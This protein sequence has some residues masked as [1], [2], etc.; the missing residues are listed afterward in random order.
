MDFLD[1]IEMKRLFL[2]V[3]K[4]LGRKIDILGMD[5]CLIS[6]DDR[7]CPPLLRRNTSPSDRKAHNWQER[8]AGQVLT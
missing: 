3:K 2:S 7:S 4:K 5:A 6:M 8:Q 1:N